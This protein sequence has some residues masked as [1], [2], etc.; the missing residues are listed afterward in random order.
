MSLNT[1]K[2][3]YMHSTDT[4]EVWKDVQPI[5]ERLLKTH[6]EAAIIGEMTLMAQNLNKRWSV[7]LLEWRMNGGKQEPVKE[8]KPDVTLFGSEMA[9]FCVRWAKVPR[10]WDEVTAKRFWSEREAIMR[11]HGVK[12]GGK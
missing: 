1:L 2:D 12:D 6:S 11:K 5:F 8:V 9:K 10:P 4:H 3:A 7:K